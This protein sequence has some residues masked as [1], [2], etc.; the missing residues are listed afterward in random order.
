MGNVLLMF[1]I[2]TSF[3]TL[4]IGIFALFKREEASAL[5]F[6]MVMIAAS[7]HAFGY[8]M[9]LL[10]VEP[11]VVMLWVQMEYI[12]IA[13]F[14]FLLIWMVFAQK[15]EE[16]LLNT[17]IGI[18]F[19]GVGLTTFF[20]VQTNFIHHL[21]YRE[22]TIVYDGQFSRVFFH[23]G[24]WYFVHL[25]VTG[26]SFL[27]VAIHQIRLYLASRN[28][29]R[30]RALNAL[31]ALGIPMFASFIY[32]F[33]LTPENLDVLPFVYAPM[34][35]M[36][37][38]GLMQYGI[39]DLI[40]VSYKKV[41]DQI[42]EGV[43][44]IDE[45]HKVVNFNIAAYHIFR[46]T[47]EL[48]KGT[49]FQEMIRKMI[50]VEHEEY[51]GQVFEIN[52]KRKIRTYH[53]KRTNLYDKK[54]RPIGKIMVVN[55]ITKETEANKILTTLATQDALT[56]VNNRRHFFDLCQTRLQQARLHQKDVSF[57]LMDIDHFKRVNDTYGHHVGDKVLREVSELCTKTLRGTDL[58]GRYGGEEFAIL[59]YDAGVQITHNII[60]RMRETISE[61][62]FKVDEEDEI[63]LT[64][65]FGIYRPEHNEET[66]ISSIFK[67]ADK[68]LYKA[69]SDGRDRVVFYNEYIN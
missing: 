60:E 50:F 2:G 62:V 57:V 18:V 51:A 58:I 29:Y 35:L 12:G 13:F 42:S 32:V 55:D 34:G 28:I 59:I 39:F 61:H 21:Y 45:N 16:N 5:P 33:Q 25:T 19:F 20:L 31:I 38:S 15:G 9:E 49:D 23:K 65:S 68:G 26:L 63:S 36:W 69:K 47:E 7:I 67:K 10:S 43:V 8:S 52:H 27:A 6:S 24:P 66:D 44:V 54:H 56:G 3:I 48:Y 17:I 40:P 1:L 37:L 22:I 14:P 4:S 53:M 64:V 41:F 11:K 30:D 46:N